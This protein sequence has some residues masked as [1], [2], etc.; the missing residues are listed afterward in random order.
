MTDLMLLI[1][2]IV[3][4]KKIDCKSKFLYS[5]CVVVFYLKQKIDILSLVKF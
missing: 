2:Y 3:L 1:I 4:I 5:S